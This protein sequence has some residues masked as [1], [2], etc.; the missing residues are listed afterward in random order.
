MGRRFVRWAGVW[1]GLSYLLLRYLGKHDFSVPPRPRRAP[2]YILRVSRTDFVSPV[3]FKIT[4]HV[5]V[6][7]RVPVSMYY[8]LLTYLLTY[9]LTGEPRGD[10]AR[11]EPRLQPRRREVFTS[12]KDG[13]RR[14]GRG[15]GETRGPPGA[16]AG[17]REGQV[18][19][20]RGHNQ[21]GRADGGW[22]REGIARRREA[23]K[24]RERSARKNAKRAA[25]LG[26][27]A[28]R[29]GLRGRSSD[30]GSGASEGSE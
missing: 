6:G 21:G 17:G 22:W 2:R 14:E 4:P 11:P 7:A 3:R 19:E 24:A 13:A 25:R 1:V 5:V 23:G 26:A 9:L 20:Q 8:L 28:A 10:E 30:G 16:A 15:L 18:H 27:A 12:R 29:G